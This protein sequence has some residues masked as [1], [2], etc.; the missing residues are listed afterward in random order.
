MA[1]ATTDNMLSAKE[2]AAELGTDARTLRKFLRKR[3]GTIGQGNRWAIDP[4]DIEELREG[5]EAW[6]SEGSPV[7]AKA[8]DDTKPKKA[9]SKKSK[10]KKSQPA[11]GTDEEIYGDDTDILAALADDDDDV[12]EDLDDLFTELDDDDD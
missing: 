6:Q 9:K 11:G 12:I 8:D 5:F 3:S 10:S 7:K 2:A 1:T 4:D